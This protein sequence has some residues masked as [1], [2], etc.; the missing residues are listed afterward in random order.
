MKRTTWQAAKQI[1]LEK[2]PDANC[3]KTPKAERKGVD[4]YRIV[5]NEKILGTGYTKARAWKKACEKII[6]E[7]SERL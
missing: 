6:L 7:L 4:I 1:I 2:Y 5:N 3:E